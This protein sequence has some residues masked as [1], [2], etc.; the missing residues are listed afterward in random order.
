MLT[1]VVRLNSAYGSQGSDGNDGSIAS[2]GTHGITGLADGTKLLT[3]GKTKNAPGEMRVPPIDKFPEQL[4]RDVKSS[5]AQKGIT[6]KDFLV[7]ALRFALRNND[8]VKGR[9][10]VD[11]TNESG[12]EEVRHDSQQADRSSARKTVRSTGRP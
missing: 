4:Y 7:Q 8:V 1:L 12:K 3:V 10:V 2:H 9:P 6:I 11:S 5:A